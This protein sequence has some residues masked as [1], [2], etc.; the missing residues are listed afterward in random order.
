MFCFQTEVLT[1]PAEAPTLVLLTED[2]VPESVS[3]RVG[4]GVGAAAAIALAAMPKLAL[5]QSDVV[6]TA[7]RYGNLRRRL[8]IERI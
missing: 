4:T 8:I 1:L 2:P 7:T 3:G 6:P 5:A